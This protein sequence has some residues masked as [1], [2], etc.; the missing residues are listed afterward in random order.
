MVVL[1]KDASG[2]SKNNFPNQ[3]LFLHIHLRNQYVFYN[4]LLFYYKTKLA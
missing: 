3:G 2:S 4:P 1:K